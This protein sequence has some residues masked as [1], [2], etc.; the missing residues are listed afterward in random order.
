MAP[1]GFVIHIGIYCWCHSTDAER[2]THG[3]PNDIT[4][5]L[6]NTNVDVPGWSRDFATEVIYPA[7]G[8]SPVNAISRILRKDKWL[9]G[10]S[11]L[12]VTVDLV[13][14]LVALCPFIVKDSRETEV[15][16]MALAAVA[17]RHQCH[18]IVGNNNI[19][20]QLPLK[21]SQISMVILHVIP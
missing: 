8:P 18:E 2:N 13:A 5:I 3:L 17:Q 1:F 10:T 7:L 11:L 12:K 19:T 20:E 16:L 14:L 9:A 6:N 4:A 21:R 15:L